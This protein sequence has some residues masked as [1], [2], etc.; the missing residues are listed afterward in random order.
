MAETIAGPATTGAARQLLLPRWFTVAGGSAKRFI[1][2]FAPRSTM[3]WVARKLGAAV[4]RYRAR[5]D[6]AAAARAMWR[7][8]RDAKVSPDRNVVYR[9]KT[10]FV[11]HLVAA[12]V[13]FILEAQEDVRPCW[14]Y[15]G[16]DACR[17][18]SCRKCGGSGVYSRTTL[19][20]FAFHI[21]GQLYR[22]HQPEGVLSGFPALRAVIRERLGVMADRSPFREQRRVEEI[23]RLTTYERARDVA[24]VRA[25]LAAAGVRI[26]DRDLFEELR[27]SLSWCVRQDWLRV[28]AALQQ[29]AAAVDRWIPTVT[30]CH[31]PVT[32]ELV[33]DRGQFAWWAWDDQE[34]CPACDRDQPVSPWGRC[35]G[36]GT[37]IAEPVLGAEDM[38]ANLLV[39]DSADPEWDSLPF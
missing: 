34:H 13:P 3:R 39:D 30:V 10:P 18:W 27:S 20:L 17:G 35:R 7:L 6:V 21:H 38:V 4:G 22:W 32:G 1:D 36:C 31:H 14:G 15:F 23:E 5:G 11:A 24:T 16:E 33:V 12:G 28:R 25:F 9:L 26:P 29:L 2:H 19:Y 8:N 37:V